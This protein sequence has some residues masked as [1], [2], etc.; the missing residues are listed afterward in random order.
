MAAVVQGAT[1]SDDCA[2]VWNGKR[3]EVYSISETKATPESAFDTPAISVAIHGKRIFM[4]VGDQV[5][6]ANTQVSRGCSIALC[7]C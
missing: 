6:V 1:V 4:A 5:K 7:G 2:V 3:A